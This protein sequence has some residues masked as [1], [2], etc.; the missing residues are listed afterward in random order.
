MKYLRQLKPQDVMF[1]GGEMSN[2]YQHTGGLLLLD[3]SD[4]P[5]FCFEKYRQYAAERIAD[6]PQFH[7]RLHEVP[8]GLDLPYWVE[9]ENFDL[10]HHLRRIALPSPGD[11]NALVEVVSYLYSKH[12]D[13][14]RPLWEIWFIEGLADG[15]FALF[16][17]QHH[18]MMDGEGA[19]RLIETLL[20][21]EPHPPPR[22]VDHSIADARPGDKPELWRQSLNAA[23]HLYRM[24]IKTSRGLYDTLRA[25]IGK[26]LDSRGQTSE[27]ATTPVTSFNTD[28]GSERGF[29]FGSLPLADIKIIKNHFDVT[30]NEVVL[31][32]VSGSLRNYLLAR[33]ELPAESLRTS[34]AVSL[35]EE[36]DD[37]FS[38]KVT[39]RSVTLGTAIADPAE[40]LRAITEEAE[41]VK[42][43]AH[44]GGGGMGQ[45][46]MLQLLPPVLVKALMTVTPADQI[47]KMAGANVIVSNVRGSDHPSYIA[48]ARVTGM[49]PMSV[50]MPGG[51]INITCFSSAGN[52]DFGITIE[53]DL[54]P[55]PWQIIDGLHSS[56]SE[57]LALTG[58]KGARRKRTTT[59]A[60]TSAS[61]KRDPA[62]KSKARQ[63]NKRRS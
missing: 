57:L 28:I 53:P 47:A 2:V 26:R 13:R 14:C 6:I 23:W 27:K 35:R 49:Y 10:D 44:S 3:T 46:E 58:K 24:P 61:G 43:E 40:R 31:A 30:V 54:V 19:T 20:D 7:W 9:D 48:G 22:E 50:I 60:K 32:V 55:E 45:L 16:Q 18:C 5:D 8:F 41:R 25:S 29:V 59:R 38:N 1:I 12:L 63:P 51:G 36:G 34:I 62:T 42:Q 21:H 37:A 39:A 17:K 4:C 11:R 56:L 52:V 33:D 15:H